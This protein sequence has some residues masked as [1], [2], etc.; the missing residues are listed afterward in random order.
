MPGPFYFGRCPIGASI[1]LTAG[2]SRG[3]SWAADKHCPRDGVEA[4][5]RI[6]SQGNYLVRN[7]DMGV[8]WQSVKV[9]NPDGGDF[10]EVDAMVDARGT[11]SMFPASLLAKIHFQPVRSLEYTVADGRK[12]EFPYGPALVNFNG[13]SWSCPVVFG[14]NDNALLEAGPK[15]PGWGERF[16]Q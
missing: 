2:I 11:D 4:M 15:S 13:E 14:P 9:D 3:L 12:I 8:F 1:R 16:R 7:R 10:V 5:P 6:V